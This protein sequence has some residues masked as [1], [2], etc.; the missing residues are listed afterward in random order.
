MT[1]GVI[2]SYAS[3]GPKRDGLSR[4]RARGLSRTGPKPRGRGA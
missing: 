3:A 2:S 1:G 4:T